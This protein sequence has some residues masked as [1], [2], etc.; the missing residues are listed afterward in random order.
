[1]HTQAYQ[2]QCINIYTY[3]HIYIYIYGHLSPRPPGPPFYLL[4]KRDLL[5]LVLYSALSAQEGQD[6]DPIP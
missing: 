2:T 5:A 6:R 1:M 3:V 4:P